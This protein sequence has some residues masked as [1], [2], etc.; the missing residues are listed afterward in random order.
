M[1][2]GVGRS[3]SSWCVERMIHLYVCGTDYSL[4]T[5]ASHYVAS[6]LERDA[7]AEMIFQ[8][9]QLAAVV[10]VFILL[11]LRIIN[12]NAIKNL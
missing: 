8:E 6:S 5:T 10:A 7:V 1:L 9:Y 12:I 4:L 3:R 2:W 11:R